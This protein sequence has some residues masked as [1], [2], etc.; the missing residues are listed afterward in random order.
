MVDEAPNGNNGESAR[1][2]ERTD[3]VEPKWEISTMKSGKPK[4]L[5]ERMESPA[6]LAADLALLFVRRKAEG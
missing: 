3:S 1:P 4:R 6:R 2:G 5:M